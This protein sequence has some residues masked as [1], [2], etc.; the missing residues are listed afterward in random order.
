[1]AKISRSEGYY[2]RGAGWGGRTRGATIESEA[3]RGLFVWNSK[4]IS[5]GLLWM[6]VVA[7]VLVGCDRSEETK[8]ALCSGLGG[9]AQDCLAVSPSSAATRDLQRALLEVPSGGIVVLAEGLYE[10]SETLSLAVDGVTVRGAGIGKTV[11]DFS[12]QKSGGGGAGV[13]AKTVRGFTMED[14]TILNTLGD[15]VRAEKSSNIVLRRIEVDW[16][17]ELKTDNGLYGVY[18]IDSQ[19]ILVEE[20]RL[21]GATD[22][23]VYVGESNFA[24]IR[25]NHVY[26]NVVGIQVENTYDADVYGNK[27]DRNSSGIAVFNVPGKLRNKGGTRVRVF[28]NEISDNNTENFG[29]NYYPAGGGIWIIAAQDV[30][31]FDNTIEEHRTLDLGI[32]SYDSL[33]IRH[34]DPDYLPHSLSVHIH[35]NRFNPPSPHPDLTR[36]LGRL[37][38][39]EFQSSIPNVVFDGVGEL[40]APDAPTHN[41]YRICI[42]ESEQTSIATVSDPPGLDG[43]LSYDCEEPRLPSVELSPELSAQLVG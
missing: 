30:E 11:L 33:N 10:V 2:D 26:Q 34:G 16:P 28:D 14:V 13:V 8:K 15:G 42:Q 3:R 35:G 18:P 4:T 22:A 27:V 25:N 9:G 5:G 38:F 29:A 32:F 41:P 1:M 43:E 17:G 31:V 23:G 40:P 24:V 19:H 7:G 21:R 36:V 6:A 20:C 12:G 39:S 37:L